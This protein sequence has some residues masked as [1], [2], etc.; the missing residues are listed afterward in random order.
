[1]APARYATGQ[2]RYVGA[3]YSAAG[4][5]CV[6]LRLLL[7]CNRY[8]S[9]GEIFDEQ[10][11]L[12]IPASPTEPGKIASR[13]RY[14]VNSM[15]PRKKCFSCSRGIQTEPIRETNSPIFID[16]I[17]YN[18]APTRKKRTC[19]LHE[20]RRYFK[21]TLA[22]SVIGPRRDSLSETKF[23]FGKNRVHRSREP[24]ILL[25]RK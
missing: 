12:S 21:D 4:E 1:M 9:V 16:R 17:C 3:T 7:R 11:A 8:P 25:N 10:V 23:L 18:L 24:L 13:L 22:Q 6:G 19:L 14:T 2:D 5:T 20:Q 15:R